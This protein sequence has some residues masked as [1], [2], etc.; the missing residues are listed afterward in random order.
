VI[1]PN[2]LLVDG[3]ARNL[4]VMEVSLR[5]AGYNVTTAVSGEDALGKV[6]NAKPDLIISDTQ[7]GPVDGFAFCEKLKKDPKWAGIPFLFLTN[8]RSVEDKIRGLELGVEEYLTKPIFVKEILIRIKM[9]LQKRQRENLERK[10]GRTT[11]SGTLSDMAVVDLIQMMELGRKSGIIHFHNEQRRNG[12]IYFRNGQIIDAELGRLQGETAV[13]R[14]LGWSDGNFE[15]EFRAIRRNDVIERPNQA[16]LMEGMRRVDEWGRLLEQLPALD[17]IFEV[18]YHELA[19]RLG[20]IPDEVNG[21][22]RLFDGRR[23][24]LQVVDESDFGDL[25]SLEVISKLFFEGLIYDSAK[26]P[27][28]HEPESKLEVGHMW[29]KNTLRGVAPAPER[30]GFTRVLFDATERPAEPEPPAIA[31]TRLETTHVGHVSPASV[32]PVAE[33]APAPAPVQATPVPA[34]LPVAPAPAVAAPAPVVVEPPAPVATP[35]SVAALAAAVEPAPAASVAEARLEAE[36]ASGEQR[37]HNDLRGLLSTTPD[38]VPPAAAVPAVREASAPA[39]VV[40]AQVPVPTAAIAVQPAAAATA[41]PPAMQTAEQE[42]LERWL[43]EEDGGERGHVIPFPKGASAPTGAAPK[44]E[45]G[46]EERINKAAAASADRNGNG[47]PNEASINVDDEAFFSSDYREEG[48]TEGT[49]ERRRSSKGKWIGAAAALLVVVGAGVGYYVYKYHPYLGH[50]ADG[51]EPNKTSIAQKDEPKKVGAGSGSSASRPALA[52]ATQP[53]ASQ[54]T[55]GSGSGALA[56]TGAASRPA[57]GSGTGSGSAVVAKKP[58]PEP[59][60]EPKVAAKT[61]PGEPG[62]AELIA[63]AEK[64]V[65]A[66]KGKQAVKYWQKALK[67]NP[68][69]WEAMDQLAVHFFEAGQMKKA[70]ELAHQAEAKNPK[71]PYA[72]LVIGASAHEKGKKAEAKTAYKSFLE[73]CPTC[74]FVNDIKAALK[75]L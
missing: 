67:L 32:E 5:K 38:A 48:Y 52:S 30:E 23:T 53:A 57:A 73:L 62:Y 19:E 14:M 71:A 22:L 9:L 20:E 50:G 24:L 13:Y 40:E 70:L 44:R 16:L 68:D 10:D 49:S 64:L 47:D 61:E 36:L 31:A 7:I 63:E 26:G 75:S 17:T 60:P 39:V 11:F 43:G 35:A 25:E 59:K 34:P 33:P 66:R 15:V 4:R 41:K 1:K 8:Q 29:R 72:Q 6:E 27:V 56:G 21:I 18:D 46:P 45:P 74:R 65:K 3:D 55:P 12:S 58:E 42:E 37:L 2:L 51:L 69:G 54:P 28:R